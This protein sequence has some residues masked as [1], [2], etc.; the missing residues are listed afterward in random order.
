MYCYYA[1]L[2][3]AEQ[4]RYF[5]RLNQNFYSADYILSGEVYYRTGKHCFI[6]QP[7]DVVLLYPNSDSDILYPGNEPVE[8]YGFCFNGVLLPELFRVLGLEQVLCLTVRP[9]SEF[10]DCCQKLLKAVEKY[11]TQKGRLAASGCL[12]EFLQRLSME[13]RAGAKDEFPNRIRQYLRDHFRE[14]ISVN[15]LA[16]AFQMSPPTLQKIFFRYFNQ[17][18]FR[19]L[20]HLRLEYAAKQL[21][22]SNRGIKEIALSSGFFSPQYFCSAFAR[23]YGKT[24]SEYRAEY[25]REH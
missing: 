12:Y 14:N 5:R 4:L 9:N 20:Q 7:G 8:S 2:Y 16:Q 13:G 24:A 25:W 10:E 23:H 1:A 6:A 22:E 18:P 21:I 15:N 11:R 3:R 19:Y 17:T